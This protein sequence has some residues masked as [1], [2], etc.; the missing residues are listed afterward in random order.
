VPPFLPFGMGMFTLC[1]CILD[2]YNFLFDFTEVGLSLRG[3]FR[4]ALLNNVGNVKILG[5]LGYRLNAFYIMMW[6]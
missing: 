6:T 1:H 3:D 4:F 2:V 5:A